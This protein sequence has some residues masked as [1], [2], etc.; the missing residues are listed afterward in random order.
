MNNYFTIELNN[1][2]KYIVVEILNFNEKIYFLLSKILSIEN[3]ITN[4]FEIVIFNVMDNSFKEIT[5]E[6][7]YLCVKEMFEKRLKENAN[8]N[9]I[10]EEDKFNNIS[11]Y[12][13]IDINNLIYVLKNDKAEILNL[14]M[15]IFDNINIQINDYIYISDRLIKE[16]QIIRFGSIYTDKAEIIKIVRD[17]NVFYLQRYYG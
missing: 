6:E 9:N 10:T 15:E 12:K 7:E 5:E 13:I 14:E 3:K 2:N 11:K 1:K 8:S 16:K 17:D 4:L